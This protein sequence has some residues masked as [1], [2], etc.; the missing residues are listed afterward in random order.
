MAKVLGFAFQSLDLGGDLIR[1][2]LQLFYG[3]R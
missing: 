3:I 2:L 1:P